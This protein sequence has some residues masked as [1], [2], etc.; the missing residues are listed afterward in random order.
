MIQTFAICIVHYAI[1]PTSVYIHAFNFV[2][3]QNNNY[4]KVVI[5]TVSCFLIIVLAF[6]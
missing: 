5:I 6:V 1:L 2:Y 3:L 4:F